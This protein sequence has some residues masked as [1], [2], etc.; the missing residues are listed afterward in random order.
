MEVKP[1]YKDYIHKY[2]WNQERMPAEWKEGLACLTSKTGDILQQHTQYVQGNYSAIRDT[3]TA[4][5][6]IILKRLNAYTYWTVG[7]H[8]CGFHPKSSTTDYQISVVRHM[9]EKSYD[10]NTDLL[11]Y[12][13]TSDHLSIVQAKINYI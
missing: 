13:L 3:H 10:Y 8:Q 7:T 6:N 12:E 2:L 9:T 11:C 4:V 1:F 5:S